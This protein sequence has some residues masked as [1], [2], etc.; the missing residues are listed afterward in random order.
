[1][2]VTLR[3][4]TGGGG[5]GT[6]TGNEANM[7]REN[8]SEQYAAKP[9]DCTHVPRFRCQCMNTIKAKPQGSRM[10]V[11]TKTGRARGMRMQAA[12]NTFDSNTQLIMISCNAT[13][14]KTV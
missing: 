5:Q 6:H 7:T 13:M 14:R 8:P 4:V 9:H 11:D 1:M 10:F 12:N 2:C 3:R